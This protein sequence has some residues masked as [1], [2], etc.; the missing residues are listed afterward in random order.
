MGDIRAKVIQTQYEKGPPI[1]GRSRQFRAIRIG[2]LLALRS[3]PDLLSLSL[4]VSNDLVGLR[5]GRFSSLGSIVFRALADLLSLSLRVGERLL[6][7]RDQGV[8]SVLR[9]RVD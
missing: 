1:G 6:R 4:R 8:S 5:L 3:L 7:L 2:E 9:V